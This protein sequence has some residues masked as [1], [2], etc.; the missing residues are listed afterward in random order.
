MSRPST[1]QK[2]NVCG[3]EDFVILMQK[4]EVSNSV[5][6]YL[7]ECEPPIDTARAFANAFSSQ[8]ELNKD[9]LGPLNIETL[10]DQVRI[11]ARSAIRGLWA[12]CTTL[13]RVALDN[14]RGDP[15]KVKKTGEDEDS[16]ETGF[17][18]KAMELLAAVTTVHIS[19]DIQPSDKLLAKLNRHKKNKVLEFISLG[20]VRNVS[21]V[22]FLR[23]EEEKKIGEGVKLVTEGL[24]KK[25]RFLDSTWK[26]Y[27]AIKVLLLFGY[28]LIGASDYAPENLFVADADGNPITNTDGTH[29]RKKCG[30]HPASYCA[31]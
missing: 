3:K 28:L 7:G 17:R 14:R 31:I 4:Y 16:L 9:L 25:N 24:T 5:G 6:K 30:V 26:L 15:E 23:E 20:D 29:K 1:P 22:K 12:E 27:Q 21:D 10:P 11:S 19:M 8:E 2:I 18:Q 13:A